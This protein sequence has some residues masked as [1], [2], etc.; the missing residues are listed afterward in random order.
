MIKGQEELSCYF[1]E[2]MKYIVYSQTYLI[3]LHGGFHV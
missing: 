1:V 3:V 2:R